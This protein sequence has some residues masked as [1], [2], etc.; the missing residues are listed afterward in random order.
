MV[1]RAPFLPG[2]LAAVAL[3]GVGG[4][5]LR[6]VVLTSA[7]AAAGLPWATLSV[8][9]AGSLVLGV[10]L[11]EE[12]DHPRAHVLLHDVV[13]IGFCGGLTTFSTL[14][15]EVARF[16]DAGRFGLALGY[17]LLSVGA[18]LLAAATGAGVF[19]RLRSLTLPL[20]EEP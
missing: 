12:W 16:T 3:G 4:A 10:A 19:R 17:A 9:V 6:W 15:F 14:A 13:G 11:A 7:P 8:N 5:I 20:E 1:K 2:R 18:T